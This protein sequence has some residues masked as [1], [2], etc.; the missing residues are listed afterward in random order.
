MSTKAFGIYTSGTEIS[1]K[2]DDE[3]VIE[4]SSSHFACMVKSGAK[5]LISAFELFTYSPN[6]TL[7]FENLF[8]GILVPSELLN[9]SYLNTIVYINNESALPVPAARFNKEIATDYLN[10]IFGEDTGT[11]KQY[12]HVSIEPDL[13]NVFRIPE[14][15]LATLHHHLAMGEVH[16]SYT[17]II[18]GAFENALDTSSP[19]IKVQF[20]PSHVVAVL[21]KGR[22]LQFIQSFIHQSTDDLL[23]YL[24]NITQRFDLHTSDLTLHVSGIINLQADVYGQLKKY[25]RN[26]IVEDPDLNTLLIDIG[27]HPRHYFTPFFNLSV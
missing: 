22:L 17:K 13:M 27:H 4:I 6:E 21:L 1:I 20:Y 26:T 10:I 14:D 8:S 16:H 7:D 18:K 9:K 12:E 19:V 5:N 24:L 23:Y 3:L 25:F 2:N 11:Q 15:W